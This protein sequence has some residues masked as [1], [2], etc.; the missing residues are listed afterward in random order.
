MR[1]LLST[2]S[3]VAALAAVPLVAGCGADDLNPEGVADAAEATRE[4]GTA[5]VDMTVA[6]SGFGV[7]IPLT[8]KGTGTSALDS[9]KM[10]L[11]FDLNSLLALAGAQGDGRTRMVVLGKDVYVKPPKVRELALPEGATWV[12]IDLADTLKAMGVDPEGF[13]AIVNADPGAQLEALT[14]A[15]GMKKV[16][17]EKIRGAETT[18]F[19]GNVSIKDLIAALPPERRRKAQEA[20]DQLMRGTP[21]GDKPQPI[22][23]WVDDD[24]RIRRMKQ[25]VAA[26]AQEGVPAGRAE[27]TVDYRDFG[28]PLKVKAPPKGDV[29]DATRAIT[30][31]LT[32]QSRAGAVN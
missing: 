2:V 14:S 31:A 28:T 27:V 30:R 23:V 5:K 17:E 11:T 25:K 10:D 15:K 12:G 6:V 20:V 1:K 24:E 9:A 3:A 26:P 7:P 13:G 18:H 29:F 32:A 19:R 8:V 22:D 21:G 4:A 16:G